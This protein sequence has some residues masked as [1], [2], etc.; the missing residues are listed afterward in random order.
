MM[1]IDLWGLVK[2]LQI[3]PQLIWKHQKFNCI[4]KTIRR[5]LGKILEALLKT[6]L[7]LMKNL[8]K[9]LAKNL[10]IQIGLAAAETA[11]DTAIHKKMFGYGC[12]PS[13]SASCMTILIIYNKEVNDIMKIVKSLEKPGLLI[14]D[15]NETIKN[16]VKE[17]KGR[18]IRMLLDTLG[19]RLLG[20]LLKDKGIIRAGEDTVRAG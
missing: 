1:G 20:D 12:R 9:S 10:L 13:D 15:V 7:P 4:N 19:A 3:I 6:G 8:L 14:K 2:L 18:F 17:Q 11:T 16:K 5:I